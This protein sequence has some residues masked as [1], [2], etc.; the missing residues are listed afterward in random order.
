MYFLIGSCIF[1][2]ILFDWTYDGY[3]LSLSALLV[4]LTASMAIHLKIN[5]I[6]LFSF[7]A[8]FLIS[9]SLK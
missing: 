3:D 5:F 8:F 4:L 1:M 9:Y 2:K 6:Y 7:Q